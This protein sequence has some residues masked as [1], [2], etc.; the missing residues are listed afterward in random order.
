MKFVYLVEQ[1]VEP[2]KEYIHIYKMKKENLKDV[3]NLLKK[4]FGNNWADNESFVFYKHVLS[5]DNSID[6]TEKENTCCA[7]F[8]DAEEE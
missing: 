2:T 7:S 8:M 6:E 5:L 4:H 1:Q 3:K